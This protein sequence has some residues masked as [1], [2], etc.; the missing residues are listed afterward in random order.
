MKPSTVIHDKEKTQTAQKLIIKQELYNLRNWDSLKVEIKHIHF[1][2]QFKY[3]HIHRYYIL[4]YNTLPNNSR[5]ISLKA[6]ETIKLY[7]NFRNQAYSER[8]AKLKIFENMR[9]AHNSKQYIS[10]DDAI[11]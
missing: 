6:I 5:F 4:K 7:F 9:S 2:G 3:M 1:V 8:Q 10:I 11:K